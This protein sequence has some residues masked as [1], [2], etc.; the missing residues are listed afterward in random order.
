MDIVICTD[1]NYVMPAGVL[2][3]S[4]CENNKTEKI[5]FH[6]VGD[7]ELLEENKKSLTDEVQRYHQEIFFYVIDSSL[8]SSLPVGQKGQ[9]QHLT[10]AAYY[11]LFLGSVLSTTIDKVLYLDCDIIVR[12][13]L[14][15]L[16]NTDLTDYAVGCV[17][18]QN[19]GLLSFYN[20]LRYPQ[21]LGYFNSG[22]LLINLAYWRKFNLQGEYLDFLRKYPERALT[23]DQDVLNY[24]LRERKKA[25]HLKYNVQNGF[26]CKNINISWEYE[27]ELEKAISDPY[28]IHYVD[29][30]KPW[31]KGCDHPFKSEFFKYRQLTE[32]KDCPLQ[33]CKVKLSKKQIIRNFLA[34]LGIVSKRRL[35]DY[36]DDLRLIP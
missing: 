15:E 36:R 13:S 11:R 23:C 20:L 34:M 10:I 18:D 3:C 27:E 29:G 26:L 14:N 22:V 4:V 7:K 33:K 8:N 1:N 32:W 21:S 35:Y 2:I 28:I 24:V 17:T 9:S 30:I 6:I 25:L 31:M 12:S 5:R 16:W 19:E